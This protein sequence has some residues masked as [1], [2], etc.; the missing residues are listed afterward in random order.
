M[1]AFAPTNHVRDGEFIPPA[2]PIPGRVV[3]RVNRGEP[4]ELARLNF[5]AIAAAEA[6]RDSVVKTYKRL[7]YRATG[8]V[9][10]DTVTM[11]WPGEDDH[12]VVMTV[13]EVAL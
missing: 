5:R 12:S 1:A 11:I 13:S 2:P 3:I 7:G 4:V 9:N 6:Y 10:G 8:S